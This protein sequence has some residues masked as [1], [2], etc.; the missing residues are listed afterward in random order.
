MKNNTRLSE[1]RR[2]YAAAYAVH[3]TTT[4][5]R[6]ALE[7]YKGIIAAYP[8]TPEAEHSRSQIRNI[9]RTMV[10]KQGLFDADADWVLT[11]VEN[12]DRPAMV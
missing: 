3:Y 10:S 5:L 12:G 4:N 6:E 8:G 2:L 1:A 7:L 11:R 9:V